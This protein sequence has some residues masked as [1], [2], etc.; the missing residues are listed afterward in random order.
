KQPRIPLGEWFQGEG[1][2]K[3]TVARARAR[4]ARQQIKDGKN[5]NFER[6]GLDVDGNPVKT[7]R[8]VIEE[9]EQKGPGLKKKSWAEQRRS[10]TKVFAK[11]LDV[12]GTMLTE[13]ALLRAVDDYKAKVS[14]YCALAYLLPILDWAASRDYVQKSLTMIKMP[15][16]PSQDRD[17]VVQI[18]ELEKILPVL[19][20]PEEHDLSSSYTD[21]MLF[22]LLTLVRR[23]EAAEATWAEM[24]LDGS[25]PF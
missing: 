18:E 12:P 17:R 19:R 15:E 8:S 21:L 16:N 6:K 11:F 1:A 3:L 23:D 2:I 10:I 7:L 9:Y 13:A 5:P 14:A 20:N 4:T 25:E 24:R 22:L